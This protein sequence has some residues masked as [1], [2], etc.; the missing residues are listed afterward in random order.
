MGEG[1]VNHIVQATS[2]HALLYIDARVPSGPEA[3]CS[4]EG[5]PA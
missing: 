4:A 1:I 2:D 3:G 5:K